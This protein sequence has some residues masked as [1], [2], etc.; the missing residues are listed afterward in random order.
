MNKYT[1]LRVY[2]TPLMD[3]NSTGPQCEQACPAPMGAQEYA[4]D[5]RL[6][7]YGLCDDAIE[8]EII[9]ARELGQREGQAEEA[10]RNRDYRRMMEQT[11]TTLQ[12]ELAVLPRPLII[13]GS[14]T[15]KQLEVDNT[16][17]WQRNANQYDQITELEDRN[18]WQKD[19]LNLLTDRVIEAQKELNDL[20]HRTRH[21][22]SVSVFFENDN[23]KLDGA[24]YADNTS[25]ELHDDGSITVTV[26]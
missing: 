14:D 21:L 17:L 1:D 15:I 22:G 18:A 3:C 6:R 26:R 4:T 23:P 10:L 25:I 24:Y 16:S 5:A 11:V 20:K 9:K 2:D 8:N 13:M 12:R 19:Q 7:V